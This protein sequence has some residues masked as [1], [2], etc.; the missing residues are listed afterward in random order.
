MLLAGQTKQL[1]KSQDIS[2]SGLKAE[3]TTQG[4][5]LNLPPKD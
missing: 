1:S 2:S 5:I 3:I 4:L